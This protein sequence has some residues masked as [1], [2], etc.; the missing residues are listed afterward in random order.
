MWFALNINDQPHSNTVSKNTD[1]QMCVLPYSMLNYLQLSNA[2]LSDD[3]WHLYTISFELY[4]DFIFKY[5][6]RRLLHN[7]IIEHVFQTHM[8]RQMGKY[9]W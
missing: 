2:E 8:V 3:E 7:L 5:R 1:S 6:R 4:S 9:I